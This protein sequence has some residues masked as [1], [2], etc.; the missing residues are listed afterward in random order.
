MHQAH[1]R[2][3]CLGS[4]PVDWRVRHL[5]GHPGWGPT[6]CS[7]VGNIWWA[8]LSIVQLLLLAKFCV[9]LYILFHWSGQGPL[10]AC[11]SVSEGVFLMYPRR[12][13]YSMS[14][15]SSSILFSLKFYCIFNWRI[16][17]LQYCVGFCQTSTWIS[18]RYIYGPFLLNVPPW[19]GPFLIS[20]WVCHNIYHFHFMFWL[21]GCKACGIFSLTRDW[22]C[23][24]CTGRQCPNYWP[25]GKSLWR[26]LRSFYI[27]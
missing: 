15:Y 7:S 17:T 14:T 10:S 25:P 9:L 12:E 27:V 20:Y 8:T 19:W 24:P 21:F 18:Y 26:M 1:R 13:I 16:I 23:T 2:A 11:I 4:S 6:L 3:P 5:K 22:N